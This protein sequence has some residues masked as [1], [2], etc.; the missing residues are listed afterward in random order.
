MSR[1]YARGG[2]VVV[3]AD[4]RIVGGV[5]S[6]QCVQ[7]NRIENYGEYLTDAPVMRV[8]HTAHTVVLTTLSQP[9]ATL[10]LEPEELSLECSGKRVVYTDC[11][12]E[13][14]KCEI[15]PDTAM[16]YTVTITADE[17]SVENAG[18]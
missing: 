12:V 7:D 5:L 8:P 14:V 9:Y 11:R 6:A 3:R 15:L 4:G 17:R 16:V 13:S 18:E 1:I 10:G 2:E